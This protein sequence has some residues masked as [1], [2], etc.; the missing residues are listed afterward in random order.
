MTDEQQAQLDGL[1]GAVGI[2]NAEA[3]NAG[4]GTNVEVRSNSLTA[5]LGAKFGATKSFKYTVVQSLNVLSL[6]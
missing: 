2:A 3:A 1:R 6:K 4:E 5:I